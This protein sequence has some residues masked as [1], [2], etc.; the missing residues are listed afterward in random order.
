MTA[1]LIVYARCSTDEQD[2]TAQLGILLELGVAATG[3]T[4]TKA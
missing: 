3:S 2:L 4:S 1:T